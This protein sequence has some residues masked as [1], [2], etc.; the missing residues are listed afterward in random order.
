M[1]SEEVL[2]NARNK[3]SLKLWGFG[4]IWI[5]L[6]VVGQLALSRAVTF[7]EVFRSEKPSDI[8]K[9]IQQEDEGLPG[10]HVMP[11]DGVD[12]PVKATIHP[13]FSN[14]QDSKW[15]KDHCLRN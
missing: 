1:S 11:G 6:Y 14:D 10:I 2:H 12:F 8:R 13:T 3:R 9:E 15:G 7:P 5:S 4:R